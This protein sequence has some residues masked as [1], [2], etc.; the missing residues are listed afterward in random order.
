MCALLIRQKLIKT[1]E[2]QGMSQTILK[3]QR[4]LE[5]LTLAAWLTK[6]S[7]VVFPSGHY[8]KTMLDCN[9]CP[10]FVI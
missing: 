1:D 8:G 9:T 7:Y 10:P 6:A 3:G 5:Q 2:S 4:L